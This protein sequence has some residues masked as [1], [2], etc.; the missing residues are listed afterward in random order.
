MNHTPDNE[1][2]T[3]NESP[4]DPQEAA[5]LLDQTTQQARRR[6]QPNPPMLNV[7]RAFVVL[8]A[9]GGLWLSVLGQHPYAGPKPWA[10]AITYG[11]VGIVIAWS[12]RALRR[13]GAGV[14]GPAQRARNIGMGVL[15][16]GWVLVYV[17]EGAFYKTGA[18]IIYGVY[19][20]TA[21]FLIVGLAAAA[22]AAGRQDWP[23]TATCLGVAIVAAF[24][25]LTGPVY[26]WLIMGIGLCLAM[27]GN[28]AYGFWQLHQS[29]VRS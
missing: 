3:D 24:A 18:H 6:F 27:L 20:A 15:L 9:F 13:S 16:T 11:L 7:F 26:C 4:L 14:S 1:T 17:F 29:V 12:T 23:L 8:V 21:P 19:P 28:A 22:W 5:A 25:A 10:I 2:V